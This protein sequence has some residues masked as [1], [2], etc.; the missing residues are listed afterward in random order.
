M[1]LIRRKRRTLQL[2]IMPFKMALDEQE[3]TFSDGK[4]SKIQNIEP[5]AEMRSERNHDDGSSYESLFYE[6]SEDEYDE[7][8]DEESEYSNY[9]VEDDVYYALGFPVENLFLEFGRAAGFCTN[10]D[11]ST[12]ER[13]ETFSRSR[14][15]IS[16][17][18]ASTHASARN[19]PTSKSLTSRNQSKPIGHKPTGESEIVDKV[20]GE[21]LATYLKDRDELIMSQ[22]QEIQR[23]RSDLNSAK[24]QDSSSPWSMRSRRTSLRASSSSAKMFQALRR[25]LYQGSRRTIVPGSF[26]VASQGSFRSQEA[27]Q[28]LQDIKREV[29]K[30]VIRGSVGSLR[31]LSRPMSKM[32]LV[33]KKAKMNPERQLMPLEA[34]DDEFGFEVSK[35]LNAIEKK[36]LSTNA[37]TVPNILIFSDDSRNETELLMVAR[38][39]HARE[40]PESLFLATSPS[41]GGRQRN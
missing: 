20:A 8:F 10:D 37:T 28:T 17:D 31:S 30:S 12:H 33:K 36:S 39:S 3:A 1:P 38:T 11:G 5:C 9:L 26:P 40:Q 7:L 34:T 15:L 18:Q 24:C 41:P 14:S 21:L 29:T 2:D 22:A 32:R 4:E 23:L 6:S 35:Q 16:I 19:H 27:V 13:V 25:N